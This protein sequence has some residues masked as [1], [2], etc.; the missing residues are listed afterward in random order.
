MLIVK[1]NTKGGFGLSFFVSYQRSDLVKKLLDIGLWALAEPKKY[2]TEVVLSLPKFQLSGSLSLSGSWCDWDPQ[3]PRGNHPPGSRCTQFL[4]KAVIE[5]NEGIVEEA[6]V[7]LS[8]LRGLSPAALAIS[9]S[10]ITST[11]SSS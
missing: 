2:S 5:V 6:L 3:L 7:P 10:P 8:S 9:S 11:S 4:Q 1:N